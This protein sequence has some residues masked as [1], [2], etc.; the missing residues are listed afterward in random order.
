MS[1]RSFFSIP[2]L[3]RAAALVLLPLLAGACGKKSAPKDPPPI[4][5]G[6]KAPSAP[7]VRKRT[8]IPSLPPFAGSGSSTQLTPITELHEPPGP[9]DLAVY[10]KVAVV[11]WASSS[12]TPIGVSIDEAESFKARNRRILEG[13]V[14]EAAKNG[15]KMVITPEFAIVGYPNIPELPSEEDQFRSRDE[16]R[17]YVEPVGGT[18]TVYFGALAKELGI[19]IHFG[20]AEVDPRNDRFYNTVVAVDPE[21]RVVGRYRKMSLYGLEY[22]FLDAGTE[23]VTYDS[24]FGKIGFA[25]C[26][27]IYQAEPIETYRG[28][29]VA[30]IALS[31][32]WAQWNTGI[33]AF[34]RGAQRANATVLVANQNYFPDSGVINPDGTLQSHIRQSDGIAYGYLPFLES[35]QTL[36]IK[37]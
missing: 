11:Q 15:A 26:S 25:I 9:I 8:P 30:V 4:Q 34:Q 10:G 18:S 14:R 7:P 1:H 36:E 23:P 24:M 2:C 27:D 16:V 37:E 32:S 12:D 19:Y 20:F 35:A 5:D 3:A 13:Y 22:R 6:A 31:T 29:G 21:G 28:L 17:P 33:H